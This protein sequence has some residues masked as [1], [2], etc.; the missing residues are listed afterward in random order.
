MHL[1]PQSMQDVPRS[2]KKVH[3]F[4]IL[5]LPLPSSPK[6]L[7]VFSQQKHLMLYLKKKEFEQAPV[8]VN[9][10]CVRGVPCA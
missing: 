4:M 3:Y 10:P 7:I 5:P 8:Q 2:S 9:W 6:A 1:K